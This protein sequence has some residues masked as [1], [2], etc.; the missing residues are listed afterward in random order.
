MKK[1]IIYVLKVTNK[2]HTRIIFIELDDDIS[3]D[4]CFYARLIRF[5]VVEFGKY[6]NLNNDNSSVEHSQKITHT[7]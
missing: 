6:F 7:D 2:V 5:P 3:R 1:R 4:L